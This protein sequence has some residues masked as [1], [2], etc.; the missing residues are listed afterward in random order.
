MAFLGPLPQ[1]EIMTGFPEKVS[2]WT[3]I[4]FFPGYNNTLEQ[5]VFHK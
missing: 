5:R 1:T 2:D 4:Y 3:V